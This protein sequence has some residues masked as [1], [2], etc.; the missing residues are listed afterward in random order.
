[1]SRIEK[2]L[3]EAIRLR[4]SVSGTGSLKTPVPPENGGERPI[5]VPNS[6]YLVT[7]TEPDSPISEEYRKL[8]TMIARLTKRDTFRNMLMVTSSVSGEGKSITCLNLAVI[9]A[10]EY[11]HTVLLI[12]ADL[13]RPSLHDYLGIPQHA[14]LSDCLTGAADLKDAIVKTGIPK[15]SLLTS[16]G[17]TAN[18]VELLSSSR[19]RE[20]LREIKGRYRDRYIIIDTPPLLPYAETHALTALVDG[21]VFVVKEGST[22]LKSVRDSLDIMK[23][24]ALLGIVYNDVSAE[25]LKGRYDYYYNNPYVNRE[26]GA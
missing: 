21:V 6:P 5:F 2:A 20:L 3:E 16:G 8:K 4:G 11:N 15:L 23:E 19:M 1:M 14:G 13:R 17:R 25:S 10:Q 22:S 12:D 9:M 18:P 7:L 26:K 24:S